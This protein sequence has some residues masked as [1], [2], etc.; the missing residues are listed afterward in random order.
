M[1]TL[2]RKRA[3]NE[4]PTPPLSPDEKKYAVEKWLEYKHILDKKSTWQTRKTIYRTIYNF[5]IGIDK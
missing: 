5:V 1:A 2:K 3:R 4:N